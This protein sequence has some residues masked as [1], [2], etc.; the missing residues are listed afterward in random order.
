MCGQSVFLPKF[1]GADGYFQNSL[2][3][4]CHQRSCKML[5]SM[6]ARPNSSASSSHVD[7]DTASPPAAEPTMAA[8]QDSTSRLTPALPPA[9]AA[10]RN[11][12]VD[13]VL[14]DL[15]KS[16]LFMTTL[17][18]NDE[19]AALQALAYEGTPLEN[20]AD[21]KQ[22]GNE[23]FAEKKFADAREFYGKGIAILAGEESRRAR[24]E[25][26]APHETMEDG[27]DQED[28][29]APG[30]IA[31]QRNLLETLYVNRA[32][33]QL[34]LRN[35]RSC[36]QDCGGA[37]RLNPRNVK[38]YWKSAK[39]LLAVNRIDEADDACARGLEID[40]SNLQLKAL[41]EEIK[42]HSAGVAA[43][44][45]KDLA[46]I[47]Q[48]RR[49]ELL[50]KAAL[51]ARG[52]KR[53]FTAAKAPPAESEMKIALVPD[54]DDPHSSLTFPVVLLYPVDMQSD[55]IRA[56]AETDSLEQHFAYVFPLPWDKNGAYTAAGVECY[57]ETKGATALAKVGKKMSLLRVL[58][59]GKIELVDD[60]LAV[61]VLPKAR[62]EKW[63]A[64]W[65]E[66]HAVKKQS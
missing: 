23:C 53:R 46:R 57:M 55:W 40:G 33:C 54:P 30:T 25:P 17:E 49:R 48:E 18:E 26:A 64:E 14:A 5:S 27:G 43:K 66:T 62:A 37:L 61:Y 42:A 12:T 7:T 45:Q 63:V 22:R 6:G 31:K 11:M 13:E 58:T 2:E 34:L 38:A 3:L 56:F 24:G 9:L 60:A 10:A 16:P 1:F 39:A 19:V 52:I 44:Q 51:L 36:I 32:Q 4:A 59:E 28:P 21:F 50:V 8:Q 35:Y 47:R 41:A 20:A 15:N 29:D 65:K